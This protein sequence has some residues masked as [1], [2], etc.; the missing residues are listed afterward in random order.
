MEN[1]WVG[2]VRSRT[3]FLLQLL[4]LNMLLQEDAVLRFCGW[5][6][7]YSTMTFSFPKHQFT[8]TTLLA[9][10]FVHVKVSDKSKL[11]WQKYEGCK[12]DLSKKAQDHPSS[13]R[14]NLCDTRQKFWSSK[15]PKLIVSEPL[16][17]L[18]EVLTISTFAK[19]N[20]SAKRLFLSVC[21]SRAAQPTYFQWW[22]SRHVSTS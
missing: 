5:E 3:P 17:S 21:V 19:I 7:S 22:R 16:W 8:A 14:Q 6:I 11:I 18:P 20:N 15:E 13:T 9:P 12:S 10:S 1:L 4:K 2:L